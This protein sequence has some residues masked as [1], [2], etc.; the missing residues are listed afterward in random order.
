M[1]T[2]MNPNFYNNY[3]SPEEYDLYELDDYLLQEKYANIS[4]II[5]QAKAEASL[6]RNL[7]GTAKSTLRSN[8]GNRVQTFS[9]SKP[10]I[11]QSPELNIPDFSPNQINFPDFKPPAVRSVEK[12]FTSQLYGSEHAMTAD[13]AIELTRRARI[14]SYKKP[15]PPRLEKD[16]ARIKQQKEQAILK[17]TPSKLQQ[18]LARINKQK[19]GPSR[20]ERDLAR[21][22]S[23]QKQTVVQQSPSRLDQ[24]LA[25]KNKR[26]N[27][28]SNEEYRQSLVKQ[29]IGK[30]DNEQYLRT[31]AGQSQQ[32]T[33]LVRRGQQLPESTQQARGLLPAGR[34]TSSEVATANEQY[35][36]TIAGQSQQPTALVRRGQQLPESTQ[37]VRGLLP[38]GRDTSSEVAAANEQYLRTIAG[39]SQQPKALVRRGQQISE[40]TQGINSTSNSNN[41]DP[42]SKTRII[43]PL[44]GAALG[45]AGGMLYKTL[46]GAKKTKR[47]AESNVPLWA[48]G[49]GGLG[50][51]AGMGYVASHESK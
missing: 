6:A 3:F 32:P 25:R 38:A 12:P 20:L 34:D 1:T 33:A 28:Y 48:L 27:N 16:L 4:N 47:V 13:E 21:R 15:S 39:Q 36:R 8:R 23:Q 44:A 14:D 9:S 51:G 26:K 43:S 10:I 31:I 40:S 46:R 2:L 30:P 29:I 18:D 19:A 49:L 22:N 11:A 35:L 50:T 37:Q 45:T 24:D 41:N 5:R 7:R 42:S 17:N